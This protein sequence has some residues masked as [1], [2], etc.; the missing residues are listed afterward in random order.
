MQSAMRPKKKAWWVSLLAGLMLSAELGMS[1]AP[2]RAEAGEN[3]DFRVAIEQ[4]AAQ[5]KVGGQTDAVLRD[6]STNK[7][8][9]EIPAMN[10]VVAQAK[11]GGVAVSQFPVTG[12]VWIEPKDDGYVFIG[13]KWYRGRV[14]VVATSGGLTAVNYVDFEQ[15]LYSVVGSEM[16]PSWSMEALKAQAVAARSYALFQRGNSANTVFDVGDTQTWQVY[17]GLEKEAAST[18]AAVDATR[19]Q[20]LTYNGEIINSVFHSC[21]GGHTEN[22]EDVWSGALPYL[23]AVP[24][25]DEG[26]CNWTETVSTDRLSQLVSGIGA[27]RGLES[28]G[29]QSGRIEQI[30]VVG[31]NGQSKV[32]TGVQFRDLLGLRSVPTRI[33][34]SQWEQVAS[35]DA[36]NLAQVPAEFRLTGGRFGH[37]VGMSQYGAN[38]MAE[39]NYDYT[40]ILAHFYRGVAL[41]RIEVQ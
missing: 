24:S 1:I 14:L 10:A 28:E 33:E 35:H 11:D 16:P 40:R 6:A 21:A 3:L 38:A 26:I 34:V 31:D 4:D 27:V 15:Y 23:R 8:L 12:G 19:G 9:T 13:D 32:L 18:R 7:I 41:A 20:V 17:T 2:A 30:R 5:V 22:S 39:R 36:S 29:S 25:Y 37:G